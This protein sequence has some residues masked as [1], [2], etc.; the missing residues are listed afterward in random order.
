M[1]CG[2][3]SWL[4]LIIPSLQIPFTIV[5]G[6]K[7]NTMDKNTLVNNSSEQIIR[8]E[9]YFKNNELSYLLQKFYEGYVRKESYNS[10]VT[11][12]PEYY[13]KIFLFIIS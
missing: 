8:L 6:R 13:V 1:S 5:V 9:M 11:L 7:S 2:D 4:R 10:F 3:K 12:F